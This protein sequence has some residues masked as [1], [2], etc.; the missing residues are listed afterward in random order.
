M[1]FLGGAAIA[2]EGWVLM[3]LHSGLANVGDVVNG[4]FSDILMVK[5]NMFS[6]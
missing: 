1:Y 3:A 2:L 4:L 6:S 5:N